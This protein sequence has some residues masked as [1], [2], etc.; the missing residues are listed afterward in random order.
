MPRRSRIPRPRF[1]LDNPKAKE[2]TGITMY[3]F[4]GKDTP[5]KY[6][7]GELIFPKFWDQKKQ[8]VISKD[9]HH[10][11]IESYL[12]RIKLLTVEIYKEF[13]NGKIE[14]SRF[15]HEL[16]IRMGFKQEVIK[17][18]L[19]FF[20]FIEDWI[21]SKKE[22]PET[23]VRGTWKILQTWQEILLGY[24]KKHGFKFDYDDINNDWYEKFK[25]Y[26]FKEKNHSINYVHKGTTIVKQIMEESLKRDYHTNVKFKSFSIK[27]APTNKPVLYID[28]LE[29]VYA[30]KPSY[31]VD[32]IVWINLFAGCFT[33]MRFSDWGKIR[34]GLIKD[35][36]KRK[37]IEVFTQKTGKPVAIPY[38]PVLEKVLE[39]CNYEVP[40]VVSQIFNRYIKR[41][42]WESG[43]SE[44]MHWVSS[45]GGKTIYTT[46]S[47][48]DKISSHACRRS[49][50]S[51][52]T[53]IGCPAS[54]L[55]PITGHSSEKQFRQY[56]NIE[57]RQNA[58]AFARYAEMFKFKI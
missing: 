43:V 35:V 11:N 8:R 42:V 17:K 47:K 57:G 56:V 29:K 49:F 30:N 15:R 32:L 14:V 18:R 51:N 36:G 44:Q 45:K 37:M 23:D 50:A 48:A 19:H 13:G 1:Y 53:L 21:K 6:S 25:T 41:I 28:E 22:N 38:L 16:D 39:E 33:G 34:K 2:P 20:D 46:V 40:P 54:M 26:C 52:F 31:E 9:E 3:Y 4:Y 7:T 58:E 24:S 10:E 27:K 55:M 12:T 5:L